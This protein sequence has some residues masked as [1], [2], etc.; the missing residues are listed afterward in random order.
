MKENDE[1]ELKCVSCGHS[2]YFEFNY[3][4]SYLMCMYCFREYKGGYEE[5]YQL[6][7]GNI[8]QL[9]IDRAAELNK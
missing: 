4:R 3:D 2:T 7:K 5:L 8:H 1:T 9:K 6:N